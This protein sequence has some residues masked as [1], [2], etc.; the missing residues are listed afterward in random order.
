MSGTG[1]YLY[2]GKEFTLPEGTNREGAL[3]E[4]PIQYDP[5]D[6][7][8]HA[9][10]T[11]MTGSGKTGLGVLLLEEAALA[12]IPALVIDPKGDLTNL[13]LHFTELSA[14]SFEPW[15]DR[16][17]ARREGLTPR[18]AAEA[19]ATRWREGL[20]AWGISPSRIRALGESVRYAIYTPGSD[21]GLPVSVMASLAAPEIPWE[22]H[23]EILRDRIAGTVTA[24]LGLIGLEDVDPMRSREHI[25]LSNIFEKAW[26]QGKDL[27]MAGLIT[28]VQDPPF[29]KLGVFPVDQMVPEK[30]RNAL[31]M[32]LN[33]FLAAPAFQTWLEGEPLDISRLL[34]TPEG[35]PRHSVFYLAHLSDAERMFT[36]T[37]LFNAL[38]TWMRQQP[39][40]GDLRALVYFDEVSGYLPPV[41]RPPSKDIILR[42][43]KQ[44]RA[45]GLGLVLA[46]Q[47]P[48]D[49][50]YK[51]LSNAG[52]WMVGKLQTEQDKE[53]LLDGLEGAAPGI[54]RQEFNR[55]ISLLDKRVFLL[56]NV[57]EDRPRVFH[58]RWTMNYLAGPLTRPQI[59]ALNT[60]A[61][62]GLAE[63]PPVL[64]PNLARE[65]GKGLGE[66]LPPAIPGSVPVY[67]LSASRSPSAAMK[68]A[69][70]GLDEVPPESRIVYR[71]A[72][73]GQ[74]RVLFHSRKH[75]IQ[76]EEM[77]AVRLDQLSRQA[78]VAWESHL[79]PTL[80]PNSLEENP[81]PEAVFADSNL[82][83][84][85]VG[86]LRSIKEDFREWIYRTRTMSLRINPTLDVVAGPGT[87]EED[88]RRQ[89]QAAMAEHREEAVEALRIKYEKKLDALEEKL[90]KEEQD[91]L[92]DQQELEHRR[93]EEFGTGVENVLS[94]FSSR[95]RRIT[96]SLTKRRMTAKAKADVAEGKQTVAQVKQSMKDMEAEL[97]DELEKARDTWARTVDDVVREP[98]SPYKKNIYVSV[99]GVLWLPQYAFHEGDAWRMVP[100]FEEPAS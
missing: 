39:G 30:D 15:I 6:L 83:L 82:P 35:K 50:D 64:K 71:A 4:T 18:E 14:E 45:F 47:N 48:V 12:G 59:L 43:L 58:T 62:A 53:R 92:A 88:F 99:F 49:L 86:L 5:S 54:A 61:G 67:Y 29:E 20:D 25:L 100:A 21:S 37:L 42:L 1:R 56:H 13:L 24:I 57:H 85:D 55:M 11:G 27:D 28:Q 89:C 73:F 72:L 34:F 68:A 22:G 77:I 69:G 79:W 75:G 9:V 63:P 36:V 65:P 66:D 32:L 8:T 87:S 74:A 19:A 81:L 96:T 51:A 78:L 46:T 33:N 2:L 84:D 41:S 23:K 7:T 76:D 93:L 90:S 52:T 38:E 26:R 80:D 44:A 3:G 10:I 95:R 17:A 91:L 40:S 16:A 70:L 60:L 31:A 98:I 97:R 94:L